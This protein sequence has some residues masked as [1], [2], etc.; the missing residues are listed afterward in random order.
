[1]LI[2]VPDEAPFIEVAKFAAALKCEVEDY[3]ARVLRLIPKNE[4]DKSG[5]IKNLPSQQQR[6]VGHGVRPSPR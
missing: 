6:Q 4:G 1:M 3:N 2:H 5:N